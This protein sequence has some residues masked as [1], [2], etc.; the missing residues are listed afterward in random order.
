MI[1]ARKDFI[2]V[3]IGRLCLGGSS[4]RYVGWETFEVRE[5][6]NDDDETFFR[7]FERESMSLFKILLT[8]CYLATI[9]VELSPRRPQSP[10]TSRQRR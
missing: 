8:A 10:L 2:F 5:T 4:T 3:D 6:D 7:G 1:T 9:N